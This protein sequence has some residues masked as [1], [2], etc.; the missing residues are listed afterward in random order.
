ME[1][2]RVLVTPECNLDCYFCHMEGS[3]LRGPLRPGEAGS[4]GI[5]VMTAGD[6]LVLA[7]AARRVGVGYF[8]VSGGEPLV[9]RDICDVLASL[10]STGIPVGVT[11]NGVLLPRY[12]GCLASLGVDK[13]NVSLHSLNPEEYARITGRP[14]FR[15]AL[16]GVRAAL[17][18]GLRV[19]VNFVLLRGRN[20]GDVKLLVDLAARMGFEVQLIE[21]HPVGRGADRMDEHVPP[22]EVLKRMGYAVARVEPGRIHNRRVLILDNGVRVTIVDPVEN[23]L[24]CAGCTRVRIRWDGGVIPCINWRGEPPVSIL[25]AIRSAGSFE[26]AVEGVIKSLSLANRYRRPYYLFGPA[27]EQ[28]LDGRLP[29][30]LWPGRKTLRLGPS[31]G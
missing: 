17:D 2:I 7:E 1:D 15:L 24:F 8:R 16:E 22:E 19:K 18:A 3:G 6:Y 4:K 28:A 13:V 26:D 25:P 14:M 11:T 27:V 30:G 5:E 21:L 20:E 31:R 9:R 10:T 23:P 29:R 12:A